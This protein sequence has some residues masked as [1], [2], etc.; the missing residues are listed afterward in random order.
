MQIRHLS[1]AAG[2]VLACAGAVGAANAGTSDLSA[3][4]VRHH[5]RAQVVIYPRD[6]F[7]P[8]NGWGSGPGG[9]PGHEVPLAA[10]PN[11]TGLGIVFMPFGWGER[12]YAWRDGGWR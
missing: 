6:R 4:H 8:E 10:Y 9:Y 11:P 5:H 1:L 3:K 12:Y 7:G 2:I